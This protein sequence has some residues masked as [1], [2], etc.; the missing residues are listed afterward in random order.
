MRIW[1]AILA[2][3]VV[4]T[5]CVTQKP[6]YQWENYE[7]D[8]YGMY[9]RPEKSKEYQE[10][11]RIIIARCD[12]KGQKVPPGIRA[13]YGY[14]LYREGKLD[15]AIYHFKKE[16]E[17]WPESYV[18]MNT[19]IVNVEKLKAAKEMDEEAAGAEPA[20]RPAAED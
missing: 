6:L 7:D 16:R 1:I 3:F 13:E 14:T 2:V 19:L 5:G 12:E 18:L 20:A 11:L 17:L 8:L 10:T 4:C 9:K 15:E